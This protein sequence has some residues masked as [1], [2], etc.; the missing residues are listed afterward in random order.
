MTEETTVRAH[1]RRGTRGVRQHPRWI[2]SKKYRGKAQRVDREAAFS[3]ISDWTENDEPVGIILESPF[4]R[5]AEH[6][7]RISLV[8]N[9]LTRGLPIDPVEVISSVPGGFLWEG[10]HRILAAQ[11]TKSPY[12]YIIEAGSEDG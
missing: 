7:R 4:L 8:E 9:R 12:I 10:H 2:L 1:K 6:K 5:D 3:M 11:R